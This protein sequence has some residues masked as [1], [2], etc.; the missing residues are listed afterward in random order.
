MCG[1]VGVLRPDSSS[2]LIDAPLLQRLADTLVHRGPDD[3]G[4][5]VD[6]QAGIGLG[7]RR[8]SVLELSAEGRQPMVSA[9]GRYVLVF[10]G[11]IY[12]HL[13]LR[14]QLAQCSPV[15]GWR[16]RSDTETLLAGIEH[17]GIGEALARASGMFAFAL[18]DREQELLTLARDRMGEKPLYF[19]W[20][21]SV[22]LFAS[23][24][25]ALRRHPAFAAEID[26]DVL[27][28][29]MRRGY[30]LAPYCIYK[31]I[32][33]VMPGT[34]VQIARRAAVHTT[35]R[36]HTYWSLP[37]A[38][39]QG[40][41]RPFAGSGTQAVDQLERELKR[42]VALQ[43]V[44]DVPLGAFLSGGIDSST[45]VALMQ[46]QS[47]R[48]VKTFTIGFHEAAYDEA[49]HARQVARHL[50]TEHTEMYL[51]SREAMDVIPLLATMFDEPFGDSSAI[52]TFLVSRL[53]RGQVTV[54]LSGDGGDELFGGYRRYRRTEK[55][56]N[57][58][59]RVPARRA[60]SRAAGLLARCLG[61]G[62]LGWKTQRLA[63][64]LSVRNAADCYRR[65]ILQDCQAAF[66]LHTSERWAEQDETSELIPSEGSLYERMMQADA[67]TYLPDDILV[68]VDRTSMHVSLESRVPMLD[69]RVVELAWSLPLELKVRNGESKW[70]LKQVLDRYVPRALTERPKMGFGVPVSSWLRGD[71]RD[72]AEDLLASDRLRQDGFLDQGPVREQWSRH[73]RGVRNEGD[74]LWR[75]LMFQ[76][77]LASLQS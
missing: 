43:S 27:T 16:G 45:I 22:F 19:G 25:K 55:L 10:N 6:A 29:Y 77:W 15:P 62:T 54:S 39:E 48:A 2:E 17:W 23:E 67:L 24:L 69:H 32:R 49:A 56:W 38:V 8:L 28:M 11:E 36:E 60:L 35:P 76:A 66:V 1:L 18:W 31:G 57:G 51:T 41:S 7:H 53:A 64:Y 42:A 74:G 58:L 71:L 37:A 21:G 59:R 33:K 12:N 70:L 20:Q 26:R 14:A 44:A 63:S 9:S 75:V 30:I 72:W 73:L 50:G 13:D 65:Q 47:S 34:Y 4:V 5:W 68:K 3:A 46:A 40:R 52:A 61:S